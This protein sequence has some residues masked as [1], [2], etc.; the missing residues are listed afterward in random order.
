[1]VH[2][3]D[4]RGIQ[5]PSVKWERWT[6]ILAVLPRPQ[7]PPLGTG[8]CLW[9]LPYGAVV[10]REGASVGD[11]ALEAQRGQLFTL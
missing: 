5:P 11:P 10:R 4:R 3:G 7:L 6:G 8:Q 1:M 9:H 2:R